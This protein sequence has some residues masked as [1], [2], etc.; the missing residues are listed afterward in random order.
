[1]PDGT[2][3]WP[4]FSEEHGFFGACM[5]GD[6]VSL[7]AE[8]AVEVLRSNDCVAMLVEQDSTWGEEPECR[9]GAVESC[10]FAAGPA[11][12]GLMAVV[13]AAATAILMRRRRGR[14]G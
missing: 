3:A 14:R 6:G 4:W 5:G 11:E 12:P 2:L 10:G 7:S 1:M 8:R 13:Y 9:G